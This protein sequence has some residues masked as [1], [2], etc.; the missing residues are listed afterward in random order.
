M[1]F[2]A[3]TGLELSVI[4]FYRGCTKMWSSQKQVKRSDVR[5]QF[6]TKSSDP[7]CMYTKFQHFI[8]ISAQSDKNYTLIMNAFTL[9]V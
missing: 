7:K 3:W 2:K 5:A 1:E 6:L 9:L 8:K 4:T